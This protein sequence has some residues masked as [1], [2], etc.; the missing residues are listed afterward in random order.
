MKL[1]LLLLFISLLIGSFAQVGLFYLPC[2]SNVECV[3]MLCKTHQQ[4]YCRLMSDR[5]NGF[6]FCIQKVP[7]GQKYQIV[8]L[9]PPT[10][11]SS[12]ETTTTDNT[13]DSTTDSTTR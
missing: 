7:E 9:P 4:A 13:T 10:E 5:K 12:T 1:N 3:A 2:H 8:T 6:C 11:P